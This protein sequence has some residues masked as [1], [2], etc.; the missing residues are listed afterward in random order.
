MNKAQTVAI[1]TATAQHAAAITRLAHALAAHEGETSKLSESALCEAMH[2]HVP[3]LRGFVAECD[4]NVIGFVLFYAGFDV[5]SASS[6]FH[7]ADIYVEPDYRARGVASRLLQALAQLALAEQ[8]QWVSLT[9]LR[10]NREAHGFYTAKGFSRVAV[11]FFA[12]GAAGLEK[13][14]QTG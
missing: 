4:A 2:H 11:D 5:S 13:I 6:G 9:A 1:H 14:A 8:H 3:P 12:T 10:S 7:L